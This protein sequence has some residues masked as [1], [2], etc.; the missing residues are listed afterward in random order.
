M[1]G[2]KKKKNLQAKVTWLLGQKLR[3]GFSP[4]PLIS[5]PLQTL[6]SQMLYFSISLI[7]SGSR[8]AQIWPVSPEEKC[9]ADIFW[10]AL[11]HS[12]HLYSSQSPTWLWTFVTWPGCR[13]YC[14]PCWDEMQRASK[15]KET[16]LKASPLLNGKKKKTD[17]NL[18]VWTLRLFPVY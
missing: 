8:R 10:K 15:S 7:A 2:F 5:S 18:G 14:S 4:Q 16:L 1:A 12:M 11:L 9:T 6:A 17:F 13:L 3:L